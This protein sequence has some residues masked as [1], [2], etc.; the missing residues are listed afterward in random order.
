MRAASLEAAGAA[1]DRRLAWPMLALMASSGLPIN[2]SLAPSRTMLV[3]NVADM[4]SAAASSA[5]TMG[6]TGN[7]LLLGTLYGGAAAMLLA[8]PRSAAVVLGRSWP[9]LL[10]LL[11]LAAS[12]LWSELPEKVLLNIGHNLGV[13]LVALAAA[14]R[15][16]HRPELLPRE[17][18]LVLGANMAL[19]VAA[20]LAFPAFAVDWQQRWQGLTV[21]PNTLGALGFTAFWANAAA[22]AVNG[23]SRSGVGRL[24]LAGCALAVLAMAGADSV[25]SKM[26]AAAAL[27]LLLGMRWLVRRRAGRRVYLGLLAAGALGFALFK[28][29][30]G[31]IDL[32]WLFDLLGRD[33][34]LTG[35][36][37]VWR[38][39]Y[40]AIGARPLLGWSFDDHAYL[41]ASAGMPYSSY[42]NGVLD[43]AVNGGAAAV[44]LLALLLLNWA[45]GHLRRELLAARVAPYSL[46]FVLAYMLH[47][48]TEA[49]YVSPRG[50]MWAIFLL[51]LFLA[52]CR[53]PG[54]RPAAPAAAAFAP[55]PLPPP[56]SAAHA[57]CR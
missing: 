6:S 36:A 45:L 40:Q 24:H 37:D 5:N 16:R 57:T 10:L 18:G 30:E 4:T 3:A 13:A 32:Q 27:L 17:L 51:L 46:A 29:L 38:D 34:K 15:Y 21:H 20:V 26:S 47:N 8:R 14:L 48:L 28:L 49:S 53:R 33:S 7:L 19:Q 35:R 23:A 1:P 25:T 44:L 39:A 11:L 42:H 41:I 55:P 22:L 54:A 12:A 31:A 43:L 2:Y 52:A 9:L 50:Q 56:P